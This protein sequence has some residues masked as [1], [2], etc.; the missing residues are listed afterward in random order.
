MNENIALVT[1]ASRGIGHAIAQAL[2]HSGY[3]VIGTATS[4]EG[5]QA[6]SQTLK[7]SGGTGMVLRLDDL[8]QMEANLSSVFDSFGVPSVLVNNAGITEDNLF[9]RMKASQWDQVIAVNLTGI[10]HLTQYCLKPMIKSK[11]GRIISLS[12]VVGVT[13]NAGQANYAAAKAGVIGMSKSLAREVAKR[14]ITVNV[15]APGFIETDM[16]N[17]LSDEV[18]AAIVTKIPMGRVGSPEEVAGAVVYLA[19]GQA[20]YITGTTIHVN[21]GF[22]ME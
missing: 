1:G 11:H 2:A 16:T 5:A 6:I 19:S 17:V 3:Q 9:L 15:I 4:E 22:H 8:A 20:S 21:G 18:S 13:G 12:S 7:S 14:G 10:F